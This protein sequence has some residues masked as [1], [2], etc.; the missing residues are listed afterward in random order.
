ME[1]CLDHD[2]HTFEALSELFLHDEQQADSCRSSSTTTAILGGTKLKYNRRDII[3]LL[4]KECKDFKLDKQTVALSV[5]LVDRAFAARGALPERLAAERCVL[6]CVMIGA[7]F[8]NVVIPSLSEMAG[9]Y[10]GDH[11]VDDIKAAE[12]QVLYELGWD[13]YQ[14]HVW[15]YLN[16][17]VDAIVDVMKLHFPHPTPCKAALLSNV[18]K[19]ATLSLK[20]LTTGEFHPVV[21]AASVSLVA[22]W[23]STTPSPSKNA[24]QT[25]PP[26]S[27][28]GNSNTAAAT[29]PPPLKRKK[30]CVIDDDYQCI[31]E[32]FCNFQHFED[33]VRLLYSEFTSIR[34]HEHQEKR[35]LQA[36]IACTNLLICDARRLVSA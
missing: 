26:G 8:E 13:I 25:P 33:C 36:T 1:L 29:T 34:V 32:L 35:V 24:I 23:C 22:W 16:P 10:D 14:P 20:T 2:R 31:S 6:A 5:N 3:R 4:A 7:K 19:V 17:C 11:T 18:H 30:V 21:A 27:Q 9:S 15:T 12:L 28:A